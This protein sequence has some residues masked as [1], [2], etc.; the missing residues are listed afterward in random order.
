[1][2]T[3]TRVSDGDLVV[4]ARGQSD[5]RQF[6]LRIHPGPDQC[7]QRSR[8][9]AVSQARR[10]AER[11]RTRAWLVEGEASVLIADCTTELPAIASEP[12]AQIIDRL[13]GEFLEMP[14]LRLTQG[15]V[16]QLCGVDAHLCQA[17]LDALIGV[18]FLRRNADNTYARTADGGI[19]R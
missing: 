2:R 17:V 16:Q 12:V 19:P 14:G 7:I 11:L 10:Y 8:G 6:V 5:P 1:M 9:A 18:R 13:R 15:Q 4:E 3:P